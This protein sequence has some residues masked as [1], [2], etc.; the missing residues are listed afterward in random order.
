MLSGRVE[1]AVGCRLDRSERWRLLQVNCLWDTDEP[2]VVDQRSDEVA[3]RTRLPQ[4][5]QFGP[6]LLWRV[7][8]EERFMPERDLP[9]VK[10]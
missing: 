1:S 2:L 8:T 5:Q 9:L 6:G 7:K 10:K 3:W 4:A